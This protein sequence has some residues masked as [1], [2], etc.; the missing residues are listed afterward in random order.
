MENALKLYDAIKEL[1]EETK[2]ISKDKMFL[3]TGEEIQQ[4]NKQF[5][6]LLKELIESVEL[7]LYVNMKGECD[8]CLTLEKVFHSTL[9]L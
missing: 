4:N 6:R 1:I 7:S 5:N 8:E 2:A 9:E 3:D